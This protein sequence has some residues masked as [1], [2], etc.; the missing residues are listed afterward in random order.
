MELA[1]ASLHLLWR[2]RC[3]GPAW[4]G[5]PV[6]QRERTWA[7][8]VR[9]L[10]GGGARRTGLWSRLAVLTLL[11]EVAEETGPLPVRDR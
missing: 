1:F 5:L 4:N 2:A 9:G 6:P 3:L 8:A 7:V 10:A 11:S